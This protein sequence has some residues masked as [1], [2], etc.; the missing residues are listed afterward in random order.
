M[1]TL[2]HMRLIVH[3]RVQGVWYRASA[4]EAAEKLGI[5]GWVR[6]LPDRCVEIDASGG[7]DSVEKFIQWCYQGPPGARVTTIDVQELEFEVTIENFQIIE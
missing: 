5:K 4:K 6:N 1:G 3:G 2:R 7:A